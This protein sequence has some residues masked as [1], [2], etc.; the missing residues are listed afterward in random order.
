MEQKGNHG[1]AWGEGQAEL[2]GDEI[3]DLGFEV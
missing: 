3:L 1:S 2:Q